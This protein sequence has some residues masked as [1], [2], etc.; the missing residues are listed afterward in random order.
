VSKHIYDTNIQLKTTTT[1]KNKKI[2]L[3]DFYLNEKKNTSK[4]Q[5][6]A[7]TS[8]YLERPLLRFSIKLISFFF[9]SLS[10]S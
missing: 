6:Q 5:Q 1:T 9:H 4:K 8:Y 3:I 2:D 7:S 10:L